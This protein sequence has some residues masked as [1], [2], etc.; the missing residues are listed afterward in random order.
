M[1]QQN[2]D[3][4][5][6]AYAA[7]GRGDIDGVLAT[8]G[9][10]IVWEP[11]IGA[12]PH[13]PQAGLRRGKAAVREFFRILGESLEFE[14]FEPQEFVAQRDKVV[15]LGAY[16]ARPKGTGRRYASDWVMIFTIADGRIVSFREFADSAGL[17]DAYETKAATAGVN[18]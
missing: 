16:A 13:V 1:S 8:C 12:G 17:N 15:V 11:V 18:R 4:V 3:L 2:I 5:Q 9:D 6:Q 7:F 10:D 14:R